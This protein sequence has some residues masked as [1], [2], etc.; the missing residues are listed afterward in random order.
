[1]ARELSVAQSDETTQTKRSGQWFSAA[2]YKGN[3][4]RRENIDSKVW[5]IVADLDEVRD[6]A[7]VTKL[8]SRWEYICWTTWSSTPQ[9]LRWRVVLPIEGGIEADRFGSL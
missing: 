8:L 2:K 5:L 6:P 9:T 3:H 4:R 7:A 1:M